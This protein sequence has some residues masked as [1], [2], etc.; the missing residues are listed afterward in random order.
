MS[1]NNKAI[2]EFNKKGY[3]IIDISKKYVKGPKMPV[4]K[5]SRMHEM[6]LDK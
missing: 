1:S 2:K 6:W 5:M 3:C 4:F